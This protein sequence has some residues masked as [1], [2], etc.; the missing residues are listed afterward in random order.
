MNRR[1]EGAVK[2]VVSGCDAAKVHQFIEEA[3]NAIALAVEMRVVAWFFWIGC[4]R[5]N[6]GF[7]AIVSQTFANTVCIVA[8][9]QSC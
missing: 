5:R 3:L 4:W 1:E 8:L 2:F 9:I 7:D 6:D